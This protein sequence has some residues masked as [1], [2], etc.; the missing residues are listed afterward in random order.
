M[1]EQALG[2]KGERKRKRTS[3]GKSGRITGEVREDG[4]EEGLE[5]MEKSGSKVATKPQSL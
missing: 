2:G 3:K 4:E 1:N 5:T